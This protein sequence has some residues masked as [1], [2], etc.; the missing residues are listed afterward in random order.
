M[1]RQS[2]AFTLVELLIVIGIMAVLI[3]LLLPVLAKAREQANR[4]VCLSNLRQISASI[5]MYASNNRG[6]F[7]LEFRNQYDNSGSSRN[8]SNGELWVYYPAN[9]AIKPGFF[10]RDMYLALGYKEPSNIPAGT[11]YG[12]NQYPPLLQ[13]NPVWECPSRPLFYTGNTDYADAIG[14]SY[15]YLANGWGTRCPTTSPET[16]H[17]ASPAYEERPTGLGQG[18][19][20]GPNGARN[21]LPLIMDKVMWDQDSVNLNSGTFTINHPRKFFNSAQA[22]IAGANEAFTDGHADWVTTGFPAVLV[23]QPG[24]NAST[25]LGPGNHFFQCWWWY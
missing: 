17:F 1:R 2:R 13:A 7:P 15:M 21:L 22:S 8:N 19:L 20:G 23:G 5:F 18:A 4:A 6:H 14:T 9:S 12:F 24:N 3:A 11:N 10:R 25:R 16:S